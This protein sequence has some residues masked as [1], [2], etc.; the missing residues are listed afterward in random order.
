MAVQYVVV[1]WDSFAG[2]PPT[3]PEAAVWAELTGVDQ[4]LPVLVDHQTALG[5]VVTDWSGLNHFRVVLSPTLE[6]LDTH[7]SA[8][9][10]EDKAYAVV[11]THA[12]L[13]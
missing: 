13:D 7:V 10:N 2:G 6:I 11:R 1:L 4:V 12:G 9:G 3:A 8:A 5:E